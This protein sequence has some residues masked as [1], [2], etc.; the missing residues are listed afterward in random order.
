M[1]YL[2]VFLVMI[3]SVA[4]HRL[5]K[6]FCLVHCFIIR[7]LMFL[8][9]SQV[10]LSVLYKSYANCCELLAMEVILMYFCLSIFVECVPHGSISALA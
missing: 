2:V 3:I 8:F 6:K 7:Y 9:L 10:I 1:V 4:L 5:L